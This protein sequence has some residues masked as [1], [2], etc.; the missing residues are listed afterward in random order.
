MSEWETWCSWSLIATASASS[1]PITM[2]DYVHTYNAE[3]IMYGKRLTMQ[4][5]LTLRLDDRLIAKAKASAHIHGMSL[6]AAVA[7]FFAHLPEPETAVERRGLSPW[8]HSLLGAARVPAK[9]VPAEEELHRAYVDYLEA[10][11]R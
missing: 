2:H 8:T 1:A 3:R 7:E 11:Y 9:P 10:K 6:S 5:K 4:T